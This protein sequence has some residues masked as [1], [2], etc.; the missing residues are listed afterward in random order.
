MV[1]NNKKK[2]KALVLDNPIEAVR[3]LADDFTSTAKDDL[4]GG[5][6]DSAFQ[7][8]FGGNKVSG[9]ISLN[10][11]ITI[12]NH[13]ENIKIQESLAFQKQRDSIEKSIFSYREE[14]ELKQQI[15]Q[16][17]KEIKLLI[18]ST[19]NISAE[20]A[21]I[22]VDNSPVNPGKY[23]VNFFEMLIKMI[24]SL[25]ERVDESQTWLNV[26]SSKKQQKQY[27]SMFKKHGTT[28][29]LSNE[30]VVATQTG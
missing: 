2:K 3:N 25:R 5:I 15:E 9:D 23:H 21:A 19:N 30:R 29:G 26:F 17:L 6:T 1:Q 27:W 20:V 8:I 24:R 10:E 14:T 28:F 4:V 7:Q 11:E 22:A 13:D 16:L 12:Q 18:K